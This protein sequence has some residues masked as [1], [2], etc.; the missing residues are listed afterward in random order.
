M[1]T[2]SVLEFRKH[3]GQIIRSAI[4]G[5]RMVMT[6]RG[7]PVFRIEPVEPKAMSEDEPFY[8]LADLADTKV[9][10]LTNDQIDKL[11]YDR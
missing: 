7:K 1:K 11:I 4:N 3:A 9:S 8:R 5:R 6:Y 2:V 10:S